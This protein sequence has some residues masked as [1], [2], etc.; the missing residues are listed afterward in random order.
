LITILLAI[1]VDHRHHI[2]FLKPP[3]VGVLNNL[4]SYRNRYHR[5]CKT[6]FIEESVIFAPP[7]EVGTP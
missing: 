1:S 5:Y 7:K 6:L 4:V 2:R 3:P